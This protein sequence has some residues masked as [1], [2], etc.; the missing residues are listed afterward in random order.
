MKNLYFKVDDRALKDF[1][2]DIAYH[3]LKEDGYNSPVQRY[4]SDE[5]E[6]K[7]RHPNR[8]IGE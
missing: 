2:A 1:L 6:E 3:R 4:L 5:A 7:E 8:D